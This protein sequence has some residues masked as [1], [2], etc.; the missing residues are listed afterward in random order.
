MLF[1]KNYHMKHKKIFLVSLIL[2]A[3]LALG[4]VS[5]ADNATADGL[6]ADEADDSVQE[7]L[8]DEVLET[9]ADDTVLSAK[10]DSGMEVDFVTQDADK[11]IYPI[12]ENTDILADNYNNDYLRVRFPNQVTGTLSLYIDNSL[13]ANKTISAKTHYMF[14]NVESYNLAEGT[15][16]WEMQYSGDANYS[17]ASLNGTFNLVYKND[18]NIDV[19][20][21]KQDDDGK[22][23]TIDADNDIFVNDHDSDYF[24]V[25]FPNRVS[26]TLSL[27]IDG[28]LKA[29][30]EITAKTHYLF[31]NTKSYNLAEGTHSWKIRYSGDS[32]YMAEVLSGT[33]TLNPANDSFNKKNSK[34]QAY[35]VGVGYSNTS[36]DT[37]DVASK[38][39]YFKVKFPKQVSGTLS[40]YIDGKLKAEKKISAKTHYIYTNSDSYNL[41]AGMHKW[42]M[43][44]SGDDEYSSASVNGTFKV[45]VNKKKVTIKKAT[46]T[47]SV[48]KNKVFKTK[49]KT[50]KYA[51]TLKANN[52]AIKKVYVYLTIKGK[53]FKKTFTAKTNNKGKATFN[54]KGLTKKGTYT[55]TIQY[56]GN[57][58]Y[59]ALSKKLTIKITK[60]KCKIT[61]GKTTVSSKVEYKILSETDADYNGFV[62]VSDAYDLLNE[63]R[64][65]K[66]VWYWADENNTSKETFNTNPSNTL[67]PLERDSLL[68]E[69]AELR[70][71]E[72]VQKFDHDRPDGSA[73]WTAYPDENDGY[74]TIGENIAYGYPSCKSV[75]EGW[76][77]TDDL[78]DDQGHRRN[79]L[80]TT[81]DYV[82]IAG[83]KI[84]G[85][86]Y[87]VQIFAID[88]HY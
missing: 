76:K 7:A 77:E 31:V 45:T 63:F 61:A 53:K 35:I 44:Y 83:Y 67:K 42:E 70:A 74:Y 57:K 1:Y 86:I 43:R 69:G 78:Y 11:E 26:G 60:S 48:A 80:C 56:K 62:D 37:F 51:I 23:N 17:A 28:K 20:I 64:S 32:N 5:A 85:I 38:E 40:L 2:L 25:K 88:W 12:D 18:S 52:K 14:A 68:E 13:M 73:C 33:F 49:L 71:K 24:M 75:T 30:K 10:K 55:A 47:I 84:N 58:N 59:K 39:E 46:P 4:A 36:D 54:I 79:M 82:G 6:A 8:A 50:K 3:I 34:I 27:Y 21:V 72:L 66:G 22:I 87:W 15:H 41:N 19:S 65:E 81:G 16:I 29:E 9:S